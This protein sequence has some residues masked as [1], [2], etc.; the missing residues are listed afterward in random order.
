M[1]T[2]RFRDS[3]RTGVFGARGGAATF[4]RLAV[5][6]ALA[7]VVWFGFSGFHAWWDLV[8]K[9]LQRVWPLVAAGVLLVVGVAA[10][11]GRSARSA[12]EM[13]TLSGRSI[14]IGAVLVLG[15]GVTAAVLL[16]KTFGG[17]TPSERLDAIRTAGTIVVGTGGAVALLLAARRQRATELTLAHQR[18]VA[19]TSEY[20]AT[21]RRITELYTKA[22]DQLG[23]TKAAVRLAGLYALERLGESAPAQRQTIGNVVCAYLRMP[24]AKPVAPGEDTTDDEQK[25]HLEAVEEQQVRRAALDILVRRA[26]Q[27]GDGYWDSLRID[28]SGAALTD[29][30]LTGAH[31]SGANLSGANLAGSTLSGAMLAGAVFDDAVLVGANLAGA[32]LAG[33]SLRNVD[34]SEAELSDARLLQADLR[35]ARLMRARLNQAAM[36]GADLTNVDASRIR[37]LRANLRFAKLYNASFVDAN[38]AGTDLN[39]AVGPGADFTGAFLG[40]ARL[41]GAVLVKAKFTNAVITGAHFGTADLEG[42]DFTGT[43]VKEANFTEANLGEAVLPDE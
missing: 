34:L 13:R 15:L 35:G 40:R 10:L 1:A 30:L 5:T 38:L 39:Y 41:I 32:N 23:A 11:R 3:G 19:A 27:G 2:E 6:A 26:D 42:A 24:Y 22:A 17:G 20:D 31:L 21:E 36:Y 14:L 28:L 29:A 4:G 37:M 43:L 9:P 8:W 16:L 7:G 18:E 12:D 25:R 33:A